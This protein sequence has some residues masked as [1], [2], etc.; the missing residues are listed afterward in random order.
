MS[1]ETTKSRSD[2]TLLTV[3]AIYGQDNTHR[4]QKSRRDDTLLSTTKTLTP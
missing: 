3:D 1:L 2:D 4:S